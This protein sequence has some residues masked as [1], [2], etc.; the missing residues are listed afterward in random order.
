MTVLLRGLEIGFALVMAGWTLGALLY[1]L[2]FPALRR[3]L[4]RV[5]SPL[6]FANWTVFG[7]GRDQATIAAYTLEYRDRDAHV[8]GPWIVLVQGRPWVWHAFLWQ[9]QR[10]IADRLHRMAE[11]IARLREH[12]SPAAQRFLADHRQRI[13]NHVEAARPRPPGCT[14]DIRI[15]Q[16]RAFVSVS[17]PQDMSRL[18]ERVLLSFSAGEAIHVR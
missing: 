2:P 14:R 11:G 10:R 8:E 7:A 3:R 5:N 12:D 9:P 1:A 6:W 13:T 18:K 4:D 15:I 17:A 16:R